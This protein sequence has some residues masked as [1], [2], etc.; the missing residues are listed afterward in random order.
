MQGS[1]VTGTGFM[2]RRTCLV[3]VASYDHDQPLAGTFDRPDRQERMSVGPDD[4][5]G[6]A[7][8][9]RLAVALDTFPVDGLVA[10]GQLCFRKR[11]TDPDDLLQAF[12]SADFE[13]HLLCAGSRGGGCP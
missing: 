8:L 10:R 1:R 6:S 2:R 5:L 3:L 7:I 12:V 11:L 13:D 4:G 9:H